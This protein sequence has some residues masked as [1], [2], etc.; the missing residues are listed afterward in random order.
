ML[1]AGVLLTGQLYISLDFVADARPVAYDA[2]A[3]P[4]EIPTV[5]GSM[6]KL[7]EQLQ[8]EM[9]RGR[10]MGAISF[11]SLILELDGGLRPVPVNYTD[12]EVMLEAI[13]VL[14]EE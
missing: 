3:R 10:A 6:D 11:P 14:T 5:P 9:Q 12:E 4:L 13:R 2:S 1:L 8:A 7:Q